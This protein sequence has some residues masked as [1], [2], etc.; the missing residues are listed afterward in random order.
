MIDIATVKRIAFLSRLRIEDEKLD[1]FCQEFNDIIN[2]IE[3]LS[4]V[5]T[6]DVKPMVSA[7]QEF[8]TCRPDIVLEANQ[9]DAILKN[10][11]QKEHGY[12]VVPKVVE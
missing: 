9:A 3:D 4:E 11:P 8:I 10:A 12:F 1:S 2:W 7:T 5:D 6:K